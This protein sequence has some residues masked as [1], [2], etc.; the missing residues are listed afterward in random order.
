MNVTFT[1]SSPDCSA[2]ITKT[3]T[4]TVLAPSVPCPASIC[5]YP[6]ITIEN[7]TI[8]AC[9]TPE[10][11]QEAFNNWLA[12]ASVT[13]TFDLDG[14]GI[15]FMEDC[16]DNDNTIK[17]I[18]DRCDDRDASTINDTIQADCSCSGTDDSGDGTGGGGGNPCSVSYTATGGNSQITVVI[19]SGPLPYTISWDGPVSG[20][21]RLSSGSSY[22][23][24][25]LPVGN[26]T[27]TVTDANGCFSIQS[28]VTVSAT[29]GGEGDMIASHGFMAA[30]E[31]ISTVSSNSTLELTYNTTD[32][33]LNQDG[34]ITVIF[35]ASSAN[36]SAT[37]TKTATFTVMEG[38]CM[39]TVPTMSEWG[40]VIFGLLTMNLGVGFI[41][42]KEVLLV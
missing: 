11:I 4:F 10:A 17:G 35:T 36:C 41:R 15:C 39:K 20:F 32:L 34:V 16:N 38:D 28:N 24:P 5:S 23:I 13:G 31:Q 19:S 12:S 37:V 1:V 26:Y 2:T 33:F 8:D 22:T 9:Q 25:S 7:R 42:R 14:D 3:A 18:G 6:E 21:F 30:N 40:L 29:G 27:I